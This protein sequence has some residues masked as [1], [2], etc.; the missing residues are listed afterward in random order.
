MGQ[1][2]SYKQLSDEDYQ[3]FFGDEEAWRNE[4]K[5]ELSSWYDGPTVSMFAIHT[6]EEI[7]STAIYKYGVKHVR[8]FPGGGHGGKAFCPYYEC[9]YGSSSGNGW[10]THGVSQEAY[11]KACREA[12]E[13]TEEAQAKHDYEMEQHDWNYKL[14]KG[15]ING[16]Y[17]ARENET[18]RRYYAC[19]FADQP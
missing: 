7:G 18:A 4:E 17:P 1:T 5:P 8:V 19:G 12:R 11:E 14:H 10:P 13:M 2:D 6:R 16:D 3:R 15:V 9:V